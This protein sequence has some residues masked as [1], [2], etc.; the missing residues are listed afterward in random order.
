MLGA[1]GGGRQ[2]WGSASL[3][4]SRQDVEPTVTWTGARTPVGPASVIQTRAGQAWT[5]G[6]RLA[7][8]DGQMDRR[9]EAKSA[10]IA[11]TQ[12]DMTVS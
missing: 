10:P 7:R 6:L 11:I 5:T 3:G 2:R 8:M 12:A 9:M 1:W 4:L